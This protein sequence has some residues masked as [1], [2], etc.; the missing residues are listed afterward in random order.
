MSA[1]TS[2]HEITLKKPVFDLAGTDAVTVRRDV[3][4]RATDAG[5]L[6]VDI[7]SP[8]TPPDGARLPA[9]IVVIGNSDAGAKARLGCAFKE[10]ESFIGWARLIAASGMVAIVPA[11]GTE[12]AADLDA[13][14][15]RVR[16]DS[17]SWGID[18]NRIGLWACSGHGPNALS[19][20]MWGAATRVKC[21]VLYYPYTLDA[22]GSTGVAD[23]AK[24]WNFA[25]PCAGKSVADLAGHLQLFIARAGLDAMPHLNTTLDRFIADALGRNLAVTVVNYS[26]GAHAFDLS[27]DSDMSRETIRQSLAFMRFHLLGTA[28]R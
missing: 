6:G 17:A 8:P 25:T 26:L 20:V 11:T 14:L 18:Q 12:P 9:V 13:L 1:Q 27:D 21:A 19:A 28:G 16:A 10:W 22:E 7:Y 23:A 2:R 3:E 15:H 4:Y 5:P 24:T